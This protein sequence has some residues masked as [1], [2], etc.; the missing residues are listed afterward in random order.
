MNPDSVRAVDELVKA[1]DPVRKSQP[2]VGVEAALDELGAAIVTRPRRHGRG[3]LRRWTRGPRAVV[4]V[5]AAL[6]TAGS[7]IAA[8]AVLTAHTGK[9]PT[10]AEVA[11]GGP[12]EALDRETVPAHGEPEGG[13][14]VLQVREHPGAIG[15]RVPLAH[16][17]AADG[18]PLGSAAAHEGREPREARLGR[19]VVR[20]VQGAGAQPVLQRG[21]QG[22]LGL[23][24]LDVLA[25]LAQHARNKALPLLVGH[26]RE[27]AGQFKPVVRQDRHARMLGQ[28]AQVTAERGPVTF[29][30][31]RL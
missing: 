14:P 13:D 6:I 9:F 28:G 31:L 23:S 10:K 20:G 24:T 18:V 12:G 11:M 1:A 5:A 27:L 17:P 26:I 15:R 22:F 7:A 2:A 3:R 19:A 25:R 8:N 29:P 4:L 30:S 21:G 16:V